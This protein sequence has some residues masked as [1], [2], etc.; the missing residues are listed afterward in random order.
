MSPKTP[1][2][3]DKRVAIHETP[4]SDS[5]IIDETPIRH[6]KNQVDMDKMTSSQLTRSLHVIR[7]MS[8]LKG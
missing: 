2:I 5:Q 7:K 8:K 3:I 4:I 1:I 6:K